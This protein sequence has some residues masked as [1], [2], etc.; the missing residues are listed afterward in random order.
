MRKTKRI[1]PQET[2]L[3]ET[4]KYLKLKGNTASSGMKEG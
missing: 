4:I 3:Q 1:Y 2:T